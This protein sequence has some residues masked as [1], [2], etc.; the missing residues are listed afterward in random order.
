V[1]GSEARGSS[2]ASVVVKYGTYVGLARFTV[3]MPEFPLEVSVADFRLSQIKG[4]RIPDDTRLVER[5]FNL[6]AKDKSLSLLSFCSVHGKSH[7]K[8]R[9]YGW[10]QTADDFSNGLNGERNCRARYQQSP[11][12][13]FAKFLAVDQVNSRSN[14]RFTFLKNPPHFSI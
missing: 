6:W 1:D 10:A 14:Q 8:K 7:R 11:V 12:E 9:A 13:I 3:W 5:P 4:W 2:N